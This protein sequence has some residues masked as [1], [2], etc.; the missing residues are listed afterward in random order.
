MLTRVW[1]DTHE[2]RV[3]VT[4]SRANTTDITEKVPHKPQVQATCHTT[5]GQIPKR[6]KK[7]K[8]N[9][10]QMNLHFCDYCCT[11]FNS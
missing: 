1:G 11:V 3:A 9:T 8:V 2:T 5:P 7:K 4:Q 10:L 6:L